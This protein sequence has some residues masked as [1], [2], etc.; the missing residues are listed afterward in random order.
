MRIGHGGFVGLVGGWWV[1]MDGVGFVDGWHRRDDDGGGVGYF[2]G[3]NIGEGDEGQRKKESG[4]GEETSERGEDPPA[5]VVEA[6][7]GTGG[8]PVNDNA[9]MGV[10][11]DDWI[12]I[13]ITQAHFIS[14]GCE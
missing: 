7:G 5:M 8:V 11:L 12:L 9:D 4:E 1:V 13:L 3:L 14:S 10:S 6:V 2:S